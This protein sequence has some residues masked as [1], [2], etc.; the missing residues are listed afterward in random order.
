VAAEAFL[1]HNR[2]SLARLQRV[3]EVIEGF[4]TP[5]GMELLASVH[6]V[7]RVEPSPAR[8]EDEAV[9]RVHAWKDRKRRLMQPQ[10][11]RIAWRHLRDLGW[12][13]P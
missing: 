13:S 10:H 9:A 7:A 8:T 11:I 3:V 1:A 6:W 2:D 4:E 12:I 5:Y